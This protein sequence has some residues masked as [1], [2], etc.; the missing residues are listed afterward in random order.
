MM[1]STK[2][3]ELPEKL[4]ELSDLLAMV[5]APVKTSCKVPTNAMQQEAVAST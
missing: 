5:Q 1:A 3:A 4:L 2:L